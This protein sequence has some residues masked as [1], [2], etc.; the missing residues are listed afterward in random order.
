M[1]EENVIQYRWLGR[2][3]RGEGGGGEGVEEKSLT[4]QK[5][6]AARSTGCTMETSVVYSMGILSV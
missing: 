3:R 6:L 4:G 5:S 2:R 1:A